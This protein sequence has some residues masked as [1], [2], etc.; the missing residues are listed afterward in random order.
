MAV[1]TLQNYS[2]TDRCT[3][4]GTE[5]FCFSAEGFFFFFHILHK[6]NLLSNFMD[7]NAEPIPFPSWTGFLLQ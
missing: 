1:S 5:D 7:V 6:K 2:L 3:G 4:N